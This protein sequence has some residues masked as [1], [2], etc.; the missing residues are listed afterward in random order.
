MGLTNAVITTKAFGQAWSEEPDREIPP[1]KPLAAALFAGFL[2]EEACS[3]F[4]QCIED[5]D[6]EHNAWF[7]F[8]K[9]GEDEYTV[10]VECTLV[11]EAKPGLWWIHFRKRIPGFFRMLFTKRKDDDLPDDFRAL[12]E[13]VIGRT[14]GTPTIRWVTDDEAME[15]LY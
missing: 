2:A 11:P 12:A 9:H 15:Q 3:S 8:I 10:Y 13:R 14:T 1:G 7:F 5:D 6:W 4:S